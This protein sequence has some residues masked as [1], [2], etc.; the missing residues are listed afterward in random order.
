MKVRLTR[1]PKMTSF[2]GRIKPAKSVPVLGG[3]NKISRQVITR[4]TKPKP[5]LRTKPISSTKSTTS[6]KPHNKFSRVGKMVGVIGVATTLALPANKAINN[7]RVASANKA[8]ANQVLVLKEGSFKYP[9][10]YPPVN[11]KQ[12]AKEMR[13]VQRI[14]KLNMNKE[15]DRQ[16]AMSLSKVAKEAGV[17]PRVASRTIARS[18]GSSKALNPEINRLRTILA[19]QEKIKNV[20]GAKRVNEELQRVEKIKSILEILESMNQ[21]ERE[22]LQ[23]R[24]WAN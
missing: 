12:F 18:H 5:A 19:E 8:R 15:A 1:D 3:A 11:S 20:E 21:K 7:A 4:A 22:A 2:F 14:L 23:K 13:Q 6:T 16:I 17:S 9:T 10:R 24:A